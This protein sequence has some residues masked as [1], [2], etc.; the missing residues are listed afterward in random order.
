[1]SVVQNQ[2]KPEESTSGSQ[3]S[4]TSEFSLTVSIFWRII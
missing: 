3:S 4:A 2:S 1:M